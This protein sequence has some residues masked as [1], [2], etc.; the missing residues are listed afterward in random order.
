MKYTKTV[1]I[2]LLFTVILSFHSLLAQGLSS[3]MYL[4][5]PE[6]NLRSAP[7]GAK[8]GSILAGTEMSVL[9]ERDNWVKVQIT[10]WVWKESL[11]STMPSGA[12]GEFRALHILVKTRAEAEE[13]LKQINAGKDFSELA[14]AKSISPS[15]AKGGDL[16]F[17]SKGDF[18]SEI[19]NAIIPLKV[20][21]VSAIVETK[22][23]F[24]IFKRVK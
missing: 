12:T 10:G 1:V 22:S 9:L 19:E 14:K 5:V 23:G 3:K 17:F 8:I 13:L 4:K 15:A 11:T 24:N 20:N 6:E 21:Q 7:S 18:A 2:F 16:G